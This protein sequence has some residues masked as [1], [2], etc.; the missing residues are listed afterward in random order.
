MEHYK[1]TG[2]EVILSWLFRVILIVIFV[3]LLGRLVELQ[4]IKGGYYRSLS[5]GNRIRRITILAPRGKIL[6]RGGEVLVG[7]TEVK[8]RIIFNPQEG[9]EKSDDISKALGEEIITEW[10]RDYKLAESFAH[11]SGY[12]GLVSEDETG[13]VNPNCPEKGVR[14]KET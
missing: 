11:V 13:K 12:L 2:Q 7:N 1:E 8:K 5:E 14:G 3:L 10:V 9:Y 4:V 6:A